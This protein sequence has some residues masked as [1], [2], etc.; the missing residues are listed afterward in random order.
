MAFSVESQSSVY[1][2]QLRAMVPHGKTT[3]KRLYLL[4][5]QMVIPIC[6]LYPLKGAY[7]QEYV[8]A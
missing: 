1:N 2:L 6:I 3:A 4:I 7:Q 8:D 5:G